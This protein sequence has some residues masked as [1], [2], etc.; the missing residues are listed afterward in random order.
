MPVISALGGG[1]REVQEFRVIFGYTATSRP[2]WA[3]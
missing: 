3:T 2:A 1:G